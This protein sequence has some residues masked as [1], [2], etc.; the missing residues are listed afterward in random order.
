MFLGLLWVAP[1]GGA[2]SDAGGGPE[3]LALV[4]NADSASSKLIANYYITGRKIPPSHVFYLNGISDKEKI[5]LTTFR[6]KILLPLL[7]MIEERG[8]AASIDYIVYSA[9]FPTVID[10]TE[11]QKKFLQLLRG[12]NVA[13]PANLYNPQVS[14]N[15]L[16]YY[17]PLVVAE[18]PL[19]FALDGNT[20]YRGPASQI[21][22]RPFVGPRQEE[23]AKAIAAIDSEGREFQEAIETLQQMAELNP[24]QSGIAYWLVRFHAKNN[25]SQQATAW[26]TR[27][28]RAGW[29]FREFTV[30][31]PALRK[32]SDE[33]MFKGLVKRIPDFPF[34]TVPPQGFKH[35]YAWGV[36]GLLSAE[37]GQGNRYFLST[38]LAVTRNFASSEQDAV[39]QLITSM[40]ADHT[41]PQGTFYFSNTADVRNK[42]RSGQYATASAALKRLGHNVDLIPTALPQQKNDV[43]GL[44]TGVANFNWTGSGSRILPGAICENLTSYGGIVTH[45]SQTKLFEFIKHLA[46]G[47][48]GTVVEP[49]TVP[50][51]FPHPLIH[52]HYASGCSLA[53]AFY[54][55]VHGPFQLLIVGDALCQPWARAPQFSVQGLE[56]GDKVQGQVEL[57]FEWDQTD[58]SIAGF[59]MYLDGLLLLRSQ[60]REKMVFDTTDLS[61]GY[62]ELRIVAIANNPIQTTQRVILPFQVDNQG[63][64]IILQASRADN[65]ETD[66][67]TF[68]ATGNF[69]DSI[70]LIHNSRSLAKKIGQSG[71]F[72]VPAKLL[73]RGPVQ[74]TAIGI[75]EDSKKVVSS[76]PIFLTIEGPILKN[77]RQTEGVK[78]PEK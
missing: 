6:E 13:V 78:K 19:Y 22:E 16:T 37:P 26:L 28:I 74:V 60:L 29:S 17:A 36:N 5:D 4:V 2:V 34:E 18:Q 25:N 57:S 75:E 3:N 49:Y 43:L 21:L 39:D 45:N 56:A 73:G 48:S 8:V 38:V 30:E 63:E 53:E 76:M 64:Q 23:F 31:D 32:I 65:L 11:D 7:Q 72:R 59:E 1:W 61:D 71:E 58:L 33:P 46:A 67:L 14:I 69:G 54:Q 47:S 10:V 35:A 40:K 77:T 20:Y 9:D 50:N 51:K 41:Q 68:T 42:T 15:A 70:E 44:S 12:Q 55:G 52:A 27:A 66:T 62:H 24:N